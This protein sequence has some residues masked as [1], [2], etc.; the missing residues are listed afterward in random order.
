MAQLTG[1]FRTW[2]IEDQQLGL[3]QGTDG[4]LED[5]L[6]NVSDWGFDLRDA[7]AVALW[8]GGQDR[9]VPP[10]HSAWLA[11]HIPGAHHRQLDAEGH[12]SIIATAFEDILDDLMSLAG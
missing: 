4:W 3:A 5:D 2:L 12:L 9:L 6:A 10:A 7:R 11:D 8:N 1:E